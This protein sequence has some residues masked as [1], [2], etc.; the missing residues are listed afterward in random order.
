MQT[1]RRTLNHEVRV[2]DERTGIV[3]YIASDETLDAYNEVIRSKGWRFSMF[4]HNS[5]FVDSHNYNSIDALL[6]NVIEFGVKKHRLHNTV[7]WAVDV[8]GNTLAKKGFDMT[9]AGYL[10]AVSV[11]FKPT[12]SVSRYSTGKDAEEFMKHVRDLELDEA[13][14]PDRIFLEQEQVELS[15]V[16]LGANPNALVQMARAYKDGVL[17]DS[18]IDWMSRTQFARHEVA[19]AARDAEIYAA[20]SLAKRRRGEFLSA[21][22]SA[23]KRINKSKPKDIT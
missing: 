14:P 11:G 7:R 19:K 6:G 13:K 1:I 23:L 17:N 3:E 8:E 9:K 18:D 5:P 15:A 21:F 10:K 20:A 4:E 12:R 22:E 16:I 2:L